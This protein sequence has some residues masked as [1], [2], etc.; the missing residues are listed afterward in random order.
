MLPA[1]LTPNLFTVGIP[2]ECMPGVIPG[3]RLLGFLAILMLRRAGRMEVPISILDQDV[4][5]GGLGVSRKREAASPF[6]QKRSV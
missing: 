6:F 1:S 3:V 5:Q 2:H 4:H